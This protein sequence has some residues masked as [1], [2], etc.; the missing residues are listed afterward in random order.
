MYYL[1]DFVLGDM[2]PQTFEVDKISVVLEDG[3]R[4]SKKF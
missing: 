4:V 1:S 3:R 2:Y